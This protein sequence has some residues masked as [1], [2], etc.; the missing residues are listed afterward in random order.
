MQIVI[1][2]SLLPLYEP[3]RSCAG[4][5]ES[6]GAEDEFGIHIVEGECL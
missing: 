1:A 3:D 6:S 2:A 4:W 5:T